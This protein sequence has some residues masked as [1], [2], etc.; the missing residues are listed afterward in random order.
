MPAKTKSIKGKSLKGKS[1]LGRLLRFDQNVRQT[2]GRIIVI[3][4]DEVGL[5]CLAGPLIAAAAIL[6]EIKPRS[7]L[8][9][10]LRELDDSKKLTIEQREKLS[11]IIR[12][13]AHF[14]IASASVEEIDHLN[15]LQ[16]SLL[17]KKRAVID[18]LSKLS[19]TLKET[20]VL[21][22]G[23]KKIPEFDYEQIAVIQGDGLSASIA[24]AS[25]VAKVHRDQL[26]KELAE[27]HPQYNWHKNKGYGSATHRK[28]IVEQGATIWHRRLFIR[29]LYAVQ[30]N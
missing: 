27:I 18:L 28:A 22:D 17:A 3:G 13:H 4:V 11:P 19:F 29:N 5:G 26:M 15:I 7:K 12:E 6:P 16:A 9:T 1:I 25:V 21:V 30:P 8:V 20:I 23:N 2:H 14:S 10:H 24:A